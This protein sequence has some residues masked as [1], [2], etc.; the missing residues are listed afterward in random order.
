MDAGL[1]AEE[2]AGTVVFDPEMDDD[3]L[4]FFRKSVLRLRLLHHL[5]LH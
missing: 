3:V 1:G 4:D 5:A 2:A